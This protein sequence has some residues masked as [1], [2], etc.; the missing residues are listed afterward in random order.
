MM[1]VTQS[2]APFAYEAFAIRLSVGKYRDPDLIAIPPSK[3]NK[4]VF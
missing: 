1:D 4:R 2:L 3:A